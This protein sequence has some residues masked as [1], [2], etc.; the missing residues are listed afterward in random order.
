LTELL[1]AARARAAHPRPAASTTGDSDGQGSAGD[2]E[3]VT[4]SEAAPIISSEQVRPIRGPDARQAPAGPPPGPGA[5]R[6]DG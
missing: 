6:P 1:Q 4:A 5:D 3:P 2:S